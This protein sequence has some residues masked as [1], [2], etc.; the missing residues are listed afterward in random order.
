VSLSAGLAAVLVGTLAYSGHAGA[1]PGMPGAIHLAADILHLV[2]AGT[3]SAVGCR[4]R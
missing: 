3:G 1:T 4:S 2:A